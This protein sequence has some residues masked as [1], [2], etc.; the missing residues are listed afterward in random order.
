MEEE[1]EEEEE[2]KN[3]ELNTEEEK[4]DEKEL[5]RKEEEKDEIELEIKKEEEK[6]KEEEYKLEAEEESGLNKEEKKNE[7]KFSEEKE[8][9]EKKIETDKIRMEKEEENDL[10]KEEEKGIEINSQEEK[11]KKIIKE[12]ENE[13]E[14]ES[15]LESKEKNTENIEE[16]EKTPDLENTFFNCSLKKCSE[17]NEESMNLNLCTKCNIENG[18]YPLET[19]EDLSEKNYFDCY[20]ETQKPDGF[21]FSKE[22]QKY[23]PC[24][25]NCK[26]CDFGGND[27]INNCTSCKNNKI[28]NPEIPNSSNCIFQCTHFYYYQREQYECSEK[29]TCP[30][31]YSLEIK[32]KRKC[33]D[34]CENDNLYKIQY[35][36]QC[37]K[38][39]PEGTNYDAIEKISKDI[40]IAKCKLNEKELR[41][42]SGENITEQEINIK[43]KIFAKEFIYTNKHVTVY[44]NDLYSIALFK[45]NKCLSEIGLNIDEIDF[46][47]CFT[48]I[49]EQ[50]NIEGNFVIVIVSKIINE[51][52]TTINTFIFNATSGEKIDIIEIC[53]SEIFMIKKKLKEQIKNN[54]N[55]DTLEKLTEQ[56]INVFDPKDN[57][58]TDLC[59]HFKSP[60]EGKDIPVKDRIILF[61]PNVTLCDVGCNLKGVNLTS[62]ESICECTLVNLI[63]RNNNY[64]TKKS[65]ESVKDILSKTNVEVM[66]CYKDIFDAKIYK[67]NTGM[68]IVLILMFIQ[69]ICIIAFYCKSSIKIRT[70]IVS[71]TDR[72]LSYLSLHKNNSNIITYAMKS[73]DII[74]SAPPKKK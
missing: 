29:E 59:S 34:K 65:I 38:E 10:K 32:E 24:H 31:N 48:L 28:L 25:S 64:L 2:E 14:E 35:D 26:T 7:N 11:E 44:K 37:Y 69:I 27:I 3:N 53:G 60:I 30:D 36:G 1:E 54:A 23:K 61:F 21:Y 9:K 20:S 16:I 56:D 33:I 40:D 62:W 46:D 22:E 15:E 55:I 66:K 42:L 12:E 49:R 52:S 73:K 74:S 39:E 45:N 18:Y 8:E 57:F 13:L 6:E 71:I 58:Y 4:E 47:K 5:K 67:K 51:I 72:F 17:C 70:Y 50:N 43:A 68:F 19:K 63:N 41:L